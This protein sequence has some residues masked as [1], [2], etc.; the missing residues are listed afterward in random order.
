MR[1]NQQFRESDYLSDDNDD[2]DSSWESDEDEVDACPGVSEDFLQILLKLREK[3]YELGDELKCFQREIVLVK[4][5]YDKL[6]GKENQADREL[7]E[8]SQHIQV[9]QNKKQLKLNSVQ[10]FVTLSAQQIYAPDSIKETLMSQHESENDKSSLCVLF[11]KTELR[12]LYGR[13][14]IL[15]DEI[16]N[17]KEY[18][19]YLH[20]EKKLLAAET[21]AFERSIS[22]LQ[23]Q[24]MQIQMLKFGQLVDFEAFD[25]IKEEHTV[26][27][28]VS[29]ADVTELLD[30]EKQHDGHV[31]M[32][33]RDITLLKVQLKDATTLN[34]D[35]LNRIGGLHKRQ[36]SL[37]QMKASAN[38]KIDE[39]EDDP[40]EK[41]RLRNISITQ[42]QEIQK[43]EAEMRNLKK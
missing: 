18:M 22:S 16:K 34:T 14:G 37:A 20:N 9:Y 36:L 1:K 10:S 4:R 31:H 41:K 19:K 30:R 29:G 39:Y 3:R 38:I 26:L 43:L 8:M 6:C 2:D 21:K 35:I 24:C 25:K 40:E 28:N 13:I 23:Q 5:N 33:E 17:H 11:S 12:N 7:E 32:L 27:S 42:L 15:Q